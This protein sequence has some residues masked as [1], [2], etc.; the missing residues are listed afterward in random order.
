MTRSHS[1]AALSLIFAKGPHMKRFQS[2]FLGPVP[3][4]MPEQT[5]THI[6]PCDTITLLDRPV[7]TNKYVGRSGLFRTSQHRL[8]S[9]A[10]HP[11]QTVKTNEKGKRSRI[12]SNLTEMR[13]EPCVLKMLFAFEDPATELFGLLCSSSSLE[14]HVCNAYAS[15]VIYH[16]KE[17][18]G[19]RPLQKF[20][21]C[22]VFLPRIIS[23]FNII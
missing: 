14:A 16:I 12:S 3:N 7:M 2:L 6:S 19:W 15:T 22:T 20:M 23:S 17:R 11:I 4:P 10:F 1:A 13:H 9:Q 5:I 8:K 18:C 21:S